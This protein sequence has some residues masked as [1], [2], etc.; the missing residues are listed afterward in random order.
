MHRQNIQTSHRQVPAKSWT[1]TFS[2][3]E[4]RTNHYTTVQPYSNSRLKKNNLNVSAP[5]LVSSLFQWIITH[6]QDAAKKIISA[7]LDFLHDC[8]ALCFSV[9]TSPRRWPKIWGV[10][11]RLNMLL[12]N[13]ETLWQ[14]STDPNNCVDLLKCAFLLALFCLSLNSNDRVMNFKLRVSCQ[15]LEAIYKGGASAGEM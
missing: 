6:R 11:A 9:W 13:L 7:V 2:M 14:T 5:L 3:W 8:R 10:I 15:L 1:S 12:L 4:E